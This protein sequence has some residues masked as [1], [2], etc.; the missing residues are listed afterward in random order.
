[1]CVI[2]NE[3]T[4]KPINLVNQV[5]CTEGTRPAW[6]YN[7]DGPALSYS[8]STSEWIASTSLTLDSSTGYSLFGLA[9]LADTTTNRALLDQDNV[10]AIRNFQFRVNGSTPQWILF[11]AGGVPGTT[12]GPTV[13]A[14]RIAMGATLFWA[15]GA[16]SA[17]LSGLYVNN[18]FT[19][20]GAIVS[21]RLPSGGPIRIGLGLDGTKPWNGTIS[22]GYCWTRGLM[23]DEQWWLYREPFAFMQPMKSVMYSFSSGN[24][25][26]TYAMIFG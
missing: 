12:S 9:N 8:G 26:R 6:G 18:V 14:G 13:T 16:G 15:N 11:T 20:A 1:M 4:G 2:L 7:A 17:I 23:P 19:S 5:Q 21:S 10:G 24:R 3:Q 22:C 25:I